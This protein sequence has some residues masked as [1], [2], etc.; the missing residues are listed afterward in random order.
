MDSE[1]R[2]ARDIAAA[3]GQLLV[4]IRAEAGDIAPDDKPA[5][6]ALRDKADGEANDLITAQLQ[7]APGDA[8]QFELRSQT[9]RAPDGRLLGV[10]VD[11][12]AL[13]HF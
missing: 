5:L 2:M 7:L 13:D 6:K 3:A 12:A 10:V 1:L 8:L 9:F 11:D 4:A